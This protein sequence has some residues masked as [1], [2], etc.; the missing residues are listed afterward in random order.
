MLAGASVAEDSGAAFERRA[1][2]LERQFIHAPVLGIERG[3]DAI[4][5]LLQQHVAALLL[6]PRQAF[7]V[8]RLEFLEGDTEVVV[9]AADGA[10]GFMLR[11]DVGDIEVHSFSPWS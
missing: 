4:D 5:L 11:R 9:A 7:V 8:G 6:Q 10:A 1:G 2:V 3:I